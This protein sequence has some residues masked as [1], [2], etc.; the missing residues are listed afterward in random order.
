MIWRSAR[1]VI[2]GLLAFAIGLV[3]YLPARVAAQWV[4]PAVPITLGGVTGTLLDGHAAYAAGPGGTVENVDW[5][6]D[7]AGLVLGRL[8]ADLA[9]DSDLGGFNAR[10]TRSLFGNTRIENLSG[11]A[12]AGWLAKLGG[13]AF[14]PLSGDIGVDVSEVAFDDA[15]H[16]KALSGQIRLGNTRWQLFNPPIELGRFTAVLD[17]GDQGEA[18]L[19]IAE[20]DG[21]LAL[22]GD[23]RIDDDMRYRL[24]VRLRARAGADDRLPQLLSQL[25][26]SDDEGWYRVRENG[27]L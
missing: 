22:D 19:R 13:Y 5:H 11:S 4:G 3:V 15:L 9:V 16:I 18:R 25:G 20:S 1:Y 17:H 8:S 23:I 10:A 12:S 7:P 6:L 24:D 27:R 26:R 14:L 21:P 2:V